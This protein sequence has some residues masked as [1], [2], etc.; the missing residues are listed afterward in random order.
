[1]LVEAATSALEPRHVIVPLR[2]F[3]KSAELV[4][5][6][7]D[8]V[9]LQDQTVT[10]EPEFGDKMQI[11]Y[12]HL[13][14]AMG[15]VTRMPTIPGVNEFAFGLKTLADATVLRDRAIGMLEMAN[16]GKD[17]EHRQSWLTV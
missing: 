4:M 15:S 12:D 16:L 3:L 7:V 13:V 8:A 6:D 14:L 5:A 2:G 10:V 17:H 11:A 1:M 9:D